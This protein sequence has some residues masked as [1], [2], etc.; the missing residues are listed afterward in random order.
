VAGRQ[1]QERAPTG[2]GRARAA[3]FGPVLLLLATSCTPPA[4][5][6]PVI[7]FADT[8]PWVRH[9]LSEWRRDALERFTRDTGIAV[10]LLPE[11]ES[12]TRQLHMHLALMA[13]HASTPD[14]FAV[15]VVWP[16]MLADDLVDLKPRFSREAKEHFPAMVESFTVDG[17]LVALPYRTDM[18]VLFYR[19]DLLHKYGYRGPPST[20]SELEEMARTI[21]AKERARGNTRLWGFV[22]P[23]AADEGLTC[24]ALEWQASEGGGVI[25]EPNGVVSVNNPRAV[26]A[27]SRAASWVGTISPAGIVAYQAWDAQSAWLS[28]NAVFMRDWPSRYVSGQA[29]GS[30]V[31]D[32]F[33]VAPLPGGSAGRAHALGGFGLGVSRYSRHQPEAEA[34]VRYLCSRDAQRSRSLVTSTLPTIPDLYDDPELLKANPV[35]SHMREARVSALVARPAAVTGKAYGEVSEAYFTAV[36][37]ILTGRETADRGLAEAEARIVKATGLRPGPPG[38]LPTEGPRSMP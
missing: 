19:T 8:G 31:R 18:G 2:G 38:P 11:P 33:G 34:L 14:V 7:T 36:H 26:F 6:K 3:R 4:P 28:G 27:L 32:K 1:W 25:V 9:D 29:E 17:R 16:G 10:R 24:V 37:S 30:L 12:S 13:E 22:W 5:E 21:L 23:G 15:D 20:W 35:L